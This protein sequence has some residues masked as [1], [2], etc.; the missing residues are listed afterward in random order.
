MEVKNKATRIQLF[1]LRTPQMRAFHMSWFAFFLCFFSWFGI[2]PLMA[3][4]R[5]EMDLTTAQVGNTIIASVA[6]TILAQEIVVDFASYPTQAIEENSH[7]YRPLGLGYAN[8]G[9]LLMRIG[10]PYDSDEG[11]AIAGSLT[12]ILTGD[13][14]ATSAEMASVLGSFPKYE[15]NRESML[16]VMRNH[17]RA[18]YNAD[19]SDYESVS[20]FVTG[21]DPACGPPEM[22][23]EARE[24]WD[25]AV[26]LGERYGYR[27][28]QATVLAPTGTIGL[29]M[30]CDTTGVE[31]DFS[32]IKFKKLAGGGY[33]KIINRSVPA[34]LPPPPCRRPS[35]RSARPRHPPDVRTIA[36]QASGVTPH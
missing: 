1:S 2:A 28:A 19:Q 13:A 9:S 3:I 22:V 25:R 24:A 7:L 5:D 34:A 4:V 35:P 21:I 17:R 11:R 6:I 29:L 23:A 36:L 31:P 15:E 18:T 8:L 16:R 32:L 30:D 26:E 33:F 20:H 10:I 14:Y 27:N 12:A